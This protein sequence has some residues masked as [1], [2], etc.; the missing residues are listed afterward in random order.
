MASI[1]QPAKKQPAKK[2]PGDFR[3]RRA[4]LDLL[5]QDGPQD[6]QRLASQLGVSAMAV[7]QHLYSL[8]AEKLVD[9]REEPRPVGRPAKLWRLTP[10]ADRFFPNGHAELTIGLIDSMKTA[11]GEA[12]M[13]KLLAARSATQ[14]QDY[15]GQVKASATLKQKLEAL[16]AIRSAEGY[17][18]AVESLG[19]GRYRLV[20]NHCPICEAAATCSGL[21][22]AELSVFRMVLGDEVEIERSDHILAGARRCAYEVWARG[23]P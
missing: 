13:E 15:G 7:R 10:A 3:S 9:Y 2:Q 1:K 12:G 19:E 23:A 18:A 11:F 22:A 16:A 17:M 14:A 5:K 4:I 21:C 6:A 8:Q 20:E